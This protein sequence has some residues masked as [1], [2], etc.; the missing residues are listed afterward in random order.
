VVDAAPGAPGLQPDCTLVQTFAEGS[1]DAAVPPCAIFDI[2]WEFPSEDDDVC[3]RALIDVDASTVPKADDMSAQCLTV[4]SNV[5]YAIE[6][7]EGVPIPA[8][9]SVEVKCQLL[10]PVGVTCDEI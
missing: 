2:G 9:T 8:G 10:A 1:P 3:Y 6:R 4:G 5:E 7:R